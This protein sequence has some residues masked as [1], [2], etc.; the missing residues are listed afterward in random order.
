MQTNK[1]VYNLLLKNYFQYEKG[2]LELLKLF[3]RKALDN[4]KPVDCYIDLNNFLSA[5]FKRD[6]YMIDDRM[7]IAA[8][9]IN[10]CAHITEFFSS[11]FD[12]P[13]KI[14]VVYGNNRPMS[15]A[16][17][18]NEYDA[19]N[20]MERQ[21]RAPLMGI[22]E[23]NLNLLNVLIPYI[24]NV[25]FIRDDNAEPAVIIRSLIRTLS[26]KGRKCARIIFTKDS[27]DFQLVATCPNTHVLRVK[28]TMNGELTYTISY[29]DFFKKILSI[30]TSIGDGI[31]PELHSLYMAFAGCKDRNIRGIITWPR[32]DKLIH[33]SLAQGV[34]LNG[35]NQSFALNPDYC[36]MFQDVSVYDR[37]CAL[38]LIHQ[39]NIYAMSP[40]YANLTKGL[41]DLYDAQA[42]KE[43][44]NK[45]FRR[46]PLDL[47]VF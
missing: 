12:I 15:A 21:A 46:Y 25:Y 10:Y 47:N 17:I 45:Y 3:Y 41:V 9:V 44:N 42:V 7:S 8:S 23:E 22:I 34:I 32:A 1:T 37:Y 5:L 38:D 13:T 6:E 27:Y 33:E 40:S 20:E 28:K 14:F 26:S 36:P 4:G 35:Y 2:R 11:R 31:S 24:P 29:F 19:H 16:S 30:K 18:L 39:E 43:I